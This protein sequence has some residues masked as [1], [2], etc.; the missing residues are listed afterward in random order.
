MDYSI[1]R[2]MNERLSI[3]RKIAAM[4]V[5]RATELDNIP[6]GL[7]DDEYNNTAEAIWNRY[8]IIPLIKKAAALEY[9]ES[10]NEW[11]KK[12]VLSFGTCENKRITYKQG[13]VFR[14]YSEQTHE[15]QTGRGTKYHVWVGNLFITTTIFSE[16]EPAFVTIETL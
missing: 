6:D 1:S 8:N 9:K 11:F 16:H 2:N 10:R 7:S 12:F 13:S 15:H 4:Q 5:Q 14:T 3:S